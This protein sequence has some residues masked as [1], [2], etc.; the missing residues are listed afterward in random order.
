[1][2]PVVNSSSTRTLARTWTQIN[3]ALGVRAAWRVLQLPSYVW[4][5]MVILA[6]A[7]LSVT[8]MVRGREASRL[9]QAS[10]AARQQQLQTVKAV[11]TRLSA[12]VNDFKRNPNAA[13]REARKRLNYVAANEIVI[14]PR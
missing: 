3:P 14:V 5:G 1:L 8:A 6:M 9:A 10:L 13:E 7:A 11:N 2:K 12:D 4:L